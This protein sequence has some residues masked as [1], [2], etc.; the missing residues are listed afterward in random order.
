MTATNGWPAGLP[1]PLTRLVGRERELAEVARLV[2]ADRLVTL[3]GAGGVGK[4]RLAIE[5]AAA[6]SADF[7]D[8]AVLIDL[9]AVPGAALLPEAVA[10]ALGVEEH[11]DAG[12][13]VR[14]IRVLAGQRRLVVL[15]NCEHLRAA[16]ADLAATLLGSCP[17]VAV[18]ATSR[19]RL[20]VP[21]EV[22]WR[23]PSL[24]FPWPEHPPAP[25]DLN[26]FE[27]IALFAERAQAARPDLRIGAGEMAAICSICFRLDGIPLA[28]ELAAARSGA[29][30]LAEIASRLTGRFGLL[31]GSR[32]GPPRHQT[33]RASVEWSCQLLS[34]AERL[35]FA[36]LGVFV[37]GW[38]LVAAEAV[39]GAPPLSENQVAA[40]LA[41][42][43]DKSL[44]H[45]EAAATG[46]RY[47][48][49][50]V[51]RAFAGERLHE[52]GE[53][54]ELRA[55]HAG[56]YAE[57]A[58]RAAP[59]LLGPGQAAWAR[60]LDQETGNLRAARSWCGEDPARAALG[61]RLASGLWEYWHIRGY[62]AEGTRWLEEAL[63]AGGG[64]ERVAVSG[65]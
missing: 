56:Y 52:G 10:V 11:G 48:L 20:G 55:R 60:R 49:L 31:A 24:T 6:V 57:V 46:S 58:E 15:D 22:T 2:A 64:P 4:T 38:E 39:C 28:L 33:L 29:L 7:G 26:S 45:V 14:L 61:L 23:V 3:V 1:V 43:A 37:G 8:G 51:I 50:E 53:L 12:L 25:D 35:L 40:L 32:V 9:S 27:A 44:V 18:L 34:E 54:E 30:S 5:V 13:E 65:A 59:M 41:G 62:L 42:L 21:G 17:Q 16:C 47:R 36:R 63:G 19:E